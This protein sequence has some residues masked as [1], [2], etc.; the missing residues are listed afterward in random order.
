MPGGTGE[1]IGGGPAGTMPA[2]AGGEGSR[3][4]L[5][6]WAGFLLFFAGAVSGLRLVVHQ[7]AVSGY[8]GSSVLLQTSYLLCDP[9]GFLQIK[10]N[11][12]NNSTAFIMQTIRNN[13]SSNSHQEPANKSFVAS[14]QYHHRV[15]VFPDNASLLIE[16]LQPMDQGLYQ[17]TVKDSHNSASA[18]VYVTVLS[19]H[20]QPEARHC[21]C[22]G[23]SSGE[24]YVMTPEV[25]LTM[26]AISFLI[27]LL[28]V[29]CLHLVMKQK[30]TKE[31]A[32]RL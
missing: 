5:H 24:G 21:T 31:E 25:L 23:N 30:A 2:P 10:W 27:S 22:P 4:V 16:K 18:T 32:R 19:D 12:V 7:T 8:E 26:R 17:V 6:A 14:N 13:K 20:E 29:L 3:R 28:S 15:T 11:I 1:P 9:V